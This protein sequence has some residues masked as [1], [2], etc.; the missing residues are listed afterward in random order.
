MTLTG[1]TLIGV[2]T[3]VIAAATGGG[4]IAALIAQ[5]PWWKRL[6]V[7]IIG[8]LCGLFGTDLVMWAIGLVARTDPHIDRGIALV[9]GITGMVAAEGLIEIVRGARDGARAFT[10]RRFGEASV[11]TKNEKEEWSE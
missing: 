5:G 1:P 11:T 6:I 2:K 4:A 8:T 3:S 7:G 9:L 10:R